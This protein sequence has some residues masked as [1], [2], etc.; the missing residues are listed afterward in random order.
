[1]K[2]RLRKKQ[3]VKEFTEYGLQFKCQH[4]ITDP[5]FNAVKADGE[6]DKIVDDFLDWVKQRGF[7][8]GGGWCPINWQ[9]PQPQ[10]STLLDWNFVIELRGYVGKTP[11]YAEAKLLEWELYQW[12]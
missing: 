10:V 11:P 8:C 4:P 7:A 9:N 2:R 12:F 3:H 5:Y 6:M 1:M